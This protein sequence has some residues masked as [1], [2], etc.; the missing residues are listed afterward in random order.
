MAQLA[1][2]PHREFKTIEK[3]SFEQFLGYS[4]ISLGARKSL[5]RR[6]SCVATM[7][8]HFLSESLREVTTRE[9]SSRPMNP[10]TEIIPLNSERV[11]HASP[12]KAQPEDASAA[13]PAA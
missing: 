5:L 13:R 3:P 8:Q 2:F 7:F 4:R 11:E 12:N 1:D 9:G 10:K 6:I